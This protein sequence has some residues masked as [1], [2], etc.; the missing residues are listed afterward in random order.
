MLILTSEIPGKL[1]S[2]PLDVPG[3]VVLKEIGSAIEE[4]LEQDFERQGREKTTAVFDAEKTGTELT[5]RSREQGDFFYPMGFGKKKKLQDYFVDEKVPRD[6]RGTI[7][8]V[9]AGNDIVWIAGYRGD[10][11]FKVSDRT[12]IFLKI[13]LNK[14]L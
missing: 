14:L 6:E 9:V 3:K 2:F 13:E 5:V 1:G 7:P 8:V 11:R 12:K 10:D 4:S